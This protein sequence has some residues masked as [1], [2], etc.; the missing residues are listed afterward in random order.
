M[1]DFHR[2]LC[3]FPW[4]TCKKGQLAR[5][6]SG[7]TCLCNDPRPR[8]AHREGQRLACS[9]L[10]P[11]VTRSVHK[12]LNEF[13][14]HRSDICARWRNV[15]L[16]VSVR[17]RAHLPCFLYYV[18]GFICFLPCSSQGRIINIGG[19]SFDMERRWIRTHLRAHSQTCARAH[20]FNLL[21]VWMKF[22]WYFV[23]RPS[24]DTFIYLC[25][26]TKKKQ[27]LWSL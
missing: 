16:C 24:N 26:N 20:A 3:A 23:A 17:A 1:K 8:P 25:L 10:S 21:R 11:R 18:P 13:S 27:L 9:P 6:T 7:I 4:E 12:L 15:E 14:Y 19:C 5:G 22:I 2:G